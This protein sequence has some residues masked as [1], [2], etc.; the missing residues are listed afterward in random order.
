MRIASSC[1][2]VIVSYVR[3]D[4]LALASTVLVDGRTDDEDLALVADLNFD[5]L[6]SSFAQL[7]ARVSV[8]HNAKRLHR[9]LKPSNVLVARDGTVKLLDFGLVT[10]LTDASESLARIVGTPRYIAPEQGLGQGVTARR[11]LRRYGSGNGTIRALRRRNWGDEVVSHTK[12]SRGSCLHK[13][14]EQEENCLAKILPLLQF[15]RPRID[16]PLE[17]DLEQVD[18][19]CLRQ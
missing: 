10:E 11:Y 9:A 6:R 8:L 13:V 7:A 15:E 18:T 17:K 12:C 16:V 19:V 4:A 14:I 1:S 3:N 2:P 5:R